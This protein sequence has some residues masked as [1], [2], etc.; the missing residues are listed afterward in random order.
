MNLVIGLLLAIVA[1]QEPG[2]PDVRLLVPGVQAPTQ[3]DLH[4]TA[5]FSTTPRSEPTL[6]RTT[7]GTIRAPVGS[8]IQVRGQEGNQLVGVGLVTGLAGTGDSINMTRGLV[9]NLLFTHNIKIEAQQL[10]SRNVAVVHLEAE[11]PAGVQAGQRIDVR[12]STMGDAKSLANGTLTLSELTDITGTIVFATASGPINT[13][14]FA[15]TG[16]SAS[17]TQNVVTVGLL[18]QGGKVER[19]VPARIVSEHGFIYLDARAAHGSYGNMV[20][21]TAAI[22]A[23]YAGVAMAVPDGRTVRVQVPVDLPES[24]WM[25]FLDTI[26]RREIEPDD[27]PRVVVNERSGA[28]VMGAGVRL[29]PMAISFG[30]LTVT[31]AETPSVSQ[32]GPLSSGQTSVVPRTDIGVDEENNGFVLVPGAA[33]LQEVVEV[34]N[35]LGTTPR[36]TISV[37][38]A[39]SQAGMLLAE[40][41]RM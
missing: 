9:Q 35:V 32:P 33:T 29:R 18:A 21:I 27:F 22:N 5:T 7:I 20:R 24:S 2:V 30:N 26:L 6:G 31:V 34:L 12:V 4:S 11:L 37:L 15:V 23:I 41:V 39:M 19:S 13:G 25:S 17:V 14:G 36:D 38:E 40:I 8:L 10:T 16:D 3:P 28:I 1:A